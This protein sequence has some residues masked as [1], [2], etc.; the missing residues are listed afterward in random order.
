MAH[1]TLKTTLRRALISYLLMLNQA[2]AQNINQQVLSHQFSGGQEFGSRAVLTR[3]HEIPA[4]TSAGLHHLK[5]GL[6]PG[7]LFQGGALTPLWGEASVPPH[8][9]LSQGCSSVLT[10]HSWLPPEKAIQERGHSKSKD[11]FYVLGWE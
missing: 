7:S 6:G 4:V 8:E 2:V 5:V 3:G 11:D 1:H 9:G 10:A